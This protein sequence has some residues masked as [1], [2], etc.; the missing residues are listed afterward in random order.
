MKRHRL[1]WLNLQ[2]APDR[3]F[4]VYLIWSKKVCVYV[5]K[6]ERQSLRK[7]LLQHYDNEQNEKLERWIKSSHQLWFSYQV[8]NDSAI[9]NARERN[10][11]KKF[12]PLTNKLLQ[13]KEEQY[14]LHTTS[15]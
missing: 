3:D 6:A 12:S 13:K 9:I 8:L 2:K 14:G 10:Y 11:I 15:V 7:R 5:G 1:N 4:G